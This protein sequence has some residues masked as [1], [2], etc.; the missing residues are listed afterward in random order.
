MNLIR[1]PAEAG[2]EETA[3]LKRLGGLTGYGQVPF[4]VIRWL[5][6]RLSAWGLS[7]VRRLTGPGRAGHSL[8]GP[9]AGLI[10]SAP[11]AALGAVIRLVSSRGQHN[12]VLERRLGG[13]AK[14]WVGAGIGRCGLGPSDSSS[15][16][17]VCLFSGAI[18]LSI[19]F[20][21]MMERSPG[22]ANPGRGPGGQATGL[23]TGCD[24]VDQARDLG[25]PEEG[26]KPG[27]QREACCPESGASMPTL[28]LG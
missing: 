10:I 17:F 8:P 28:T 2:S 16:R 5:Q 25:Q 24:R 27:G 3:L 7:E 20:S 23:W 22:G 21:G 26:K 15:L 1:G 6:H 18:A 19:H 13:H 4:L 14:G 9:L 11:L 12:K